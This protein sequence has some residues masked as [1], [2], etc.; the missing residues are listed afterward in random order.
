MS[1]IGFLTDSCS[2]IPQE[3]A[4]KYGIEVVGFPINLDGVE[5]MER[6]DFTNDQFYQMMRD[7]QGVPTTAA[8]TQLQ[9]C[10]IY[11]RYA[12]EGYTDL[13]YLSIN[14]G[15]SSTY[16]NAVKAMELLEEERPGY[17]MKI[18]V[19]D[20]HTYSMPYGWYFC[21]CARKVRNGGELASCVA[22]LKKKLDCVEICLAAYSLKQMKKSGRISAAAAVMGELMGIRP[23][24]TLIDGKTKVEAKVRG[25][26]K[27]VPAMVEL[28]KQRSE[29]VENFDYMIGHTNIPQTADLE[30]ACRKAFG[31]PPLLV[32]ELGGVVSANTGPDTIALVYVGH[33]R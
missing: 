2:D 25:D 29:G 30:K 27:V 21:E 23:I 7:A 19:I 8:I 31:K 14:A 22:E 16:N 5:Y 6:K 3:L 10:D 12:D 1:K 24:I 11:A 4:D 15:G 9:F 13:V 33:A 17:T 18:Q 28:C 26:D 32:F 20:S